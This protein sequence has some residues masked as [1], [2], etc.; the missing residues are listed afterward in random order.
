MVCSD[1]GQGAIR[2]GFGL[3]VR[4]SYFK[5]P[6]RKGSYSTAAERQS[7]PEWLFSWPTSLLCTARRVHT[8]ELSFRHRTARDRVERKGK[9]RFCLSFLVERNLPMPLRPSLM[10]RWPVWSNACS[11]DNDKVNPLQLGVGGGPQAHGCRQDTTAGACVNG[12]PPHGVSETGT[13][14]RHRS[15]APPG[16]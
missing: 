6:H 7:R 13:K 4:D 11:T 14:A 10:S 9:D 5:K 15:K 2:S 8:S 3:Q 1:S 12:A 16:V